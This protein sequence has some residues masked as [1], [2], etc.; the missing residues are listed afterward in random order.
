[1]SKVKYDL[2]ALARRARNRLRHGL[3]KLPQVTRKARAGSPLLLHEVKYGSAL[4][5]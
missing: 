1:M 2:P 3:R 4:L 5:F